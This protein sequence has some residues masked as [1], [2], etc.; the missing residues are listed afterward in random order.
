M[1]GVSG[2]FSVGDSSVD[3]VF[4]LKRSSESISHRGPDASG[5][6]VDRFD[7]GMIGLAH[8]RLAIQDLSVD[9]NQPMH[10]EQ[11]VLVFNGEIYNQHALRQLLIQR[12][13]SLRTHSDTEVILTGFSV[14][15]TEFFSM[16]RGMFFIAIYSKEENL[17]YLARD[18]LGIKPCYFSVF[19]DSIYFSS[20]IKGLK[21]FGEVD[22]VLSEVDVFEFFHYGFVHEPRTG[23]SN[24]KKIKPGH[25]MTV[26][27]ED[28][29]LS[30]SE[31][32][33]L[34]SREFVKGK[35]FDEI[36]ANAVERQHIS[37]VKLGIFFSGGIDSAILA[38][39]STSQ[40]L[41]FA[42]YSSDGIF[43]DERLNAI[44]VAETLKKD[45]TIENIDSAY[46]SFPLES[47]DLVARNV[48]EPISDFT[49]FS[50]FQLS[51]A[52]SRKGFKVMLSGMGADEIFGGYPRYQAMAYHKYMKPFRKLIRFI[53]NA[54][55]VPNSLKNKVDRLSNFLDEE[56]W[57]LAYSRLVGYFDSDE[58]RSLFGN[59]LNTIFM[60]QFL[61]NLQ[62]SRSI[63]VP[64]DKES[65]S[66]VYRAMWADKTGFLAHN[67]SVADKSS[68]MAGLEL[69][70]PLLDEDL[71][72]KSMEFEQHEL[73][74]NHRQGKKPLLNIL[75][76]TLSKKQIDRKKVG[77]NPPV[78]DLMEALGPERAKEIISDLPA[79]VNKELAYQILHDFYGGQRHQNVYKLWQL[80]FFSR[81]YQLNI[82]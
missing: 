28:N 19:G 66:P 68:M 49:F 61:T 33:F 30:I 22:P 7:E 35:G 74:E 70:V 17:L 6:F 65:H 57:E 26:S 14:F 48:E 18:S 50:S 53:I 79:I 1:C 39:Q 32:S 77:F 3:R 73:L 45:L 46:L 43:G 81:W 24:I 41:L 2:F 34:S 76:K 82:A 51:S 21:H 63:F 54:R 13:F 47:I 44:H 40:N 36:L 59:D 80:I 16:L 60:E 15:G 10:N 62:N 5:E 67:L 42:S 4:E 11:N 71:V 72:Y 23:F 69:R 8:R 29:S 20:E 9:A 56:D 64:S 58:I 12:G 25:W 31:K 37:D 78:L 52:A 75:R 27:I 55:L 38:T